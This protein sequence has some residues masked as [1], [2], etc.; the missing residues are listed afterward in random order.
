MSKF[1]M[2]LCVTALTTPAVAQDPPKPR[3][4]TADVGFVSASGNS[5]VTTFNLGEKLVLRHGKWEHKQGFG[6]LYGEQ[7]GEERSNLVFANFR[8]NYSLSSAMSVF[9]YAGYD[10]NVFAGISR[11]FEEAIGV[12]AKLITLDSDVWT[13]EVGFAANQ[14]RAVD[15]STLDFASLRSGTLYR[16]NFSKQSYFFQSV[17]YLPS[18]KISEDRR[19]NSETGFVAPI[20]EHASMKVGYVV[21]FDNLPEIGKLKGD[22]ILT[23]GLQFNF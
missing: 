18:F 11:R 13:I 2:V 12:A 21:R 5:K 6:A 1:V 8:S 17:E 4:F 7:D 16:H 20:N 22:R 9:A 14:Q 23:T 19:F 15:G 10:R 3:E